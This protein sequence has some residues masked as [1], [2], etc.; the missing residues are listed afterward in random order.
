MRLDAE[1]GAKPQHLPTDCVMVSDA[2]RDNFTENVQDMLAKIIIQNY[3]MSIF[4]HLPSGQWVKPYQ[5]SDNREEKRFSHIFRRYK[6]Y[7]PIRVN[8]RSIDFRVPISNGLY[9]NFQIIFLYAHFARQEIHSWQKRLL[10]TGMMCLF[11]DY[12]YFISPRGLRT[13]CLV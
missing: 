12:F 3:L 11:C 1:N 10:H 13:G 8:A 9:I 4:V 2:K 6:Q 5:L 7:V